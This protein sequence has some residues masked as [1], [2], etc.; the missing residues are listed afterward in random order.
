MRRAAVS[1]AQ[2]PSAPQASSPI[3]SRS[4]LATPCRKIDEDGDMNDSQENPIGLL[5]FEFVEFAS[6][7]SAELAPVFEALGF[8]KIG[9]HRAKKIALYRQGGIDFIVNDEADSVATYFAAA[10]GPS[11]CGIALRVNDAAAAYAYALEKGAVPMEDHA[12]PVALRVPALQG[13]GGAPLYLVDH[14]GDGTS[15]YSDFDFIAGAEQRPAGHGLRSI[16]HLGHHV[17]GG[18]LSYWAELYAT[19]FDP[20]GMR[21][22]DFRDDYLHLATDEGP[23]RTST[24]GVCH[25]ALISDNLIDT[26][27]SL[28]GAGV[29]LAAATAASPH[30][31]FGARTRMFARSPLSQVAFEF[32]QSSDQNDADDRN[33][34]LPMPSDQVQ[35]AAPVFA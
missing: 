30:G 14:A 1:A 12:V 19:L 21:C 3:S 8:R 18:R 16:D 25:I 6:L 4:P 27:T 23:S 29:P 17:H 35:P 32:I 15:V 28:L 24:E 9:V 20:R 26:V 5:G 11:A 33:A 2:Q 34:W 10:H 31:A 13:I 7:Q 22:H